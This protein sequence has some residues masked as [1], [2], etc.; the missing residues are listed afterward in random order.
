MEYKT[1]IVFSLSMAICASCN[2]AIKES[3]STEVDYDQ[4]C[5]DYCAIKVHKEVVE[6]DIYDGMYTESQVLEMCR[7]SRSCDDSFSSM[8]LPRCYESLPERCPPDSYWEPF[9]SVGEAGACLEALQNVP[10]E[11]LGDIPRECDSDA[12]CDPE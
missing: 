5:E 4:Y 10:C 8:C 12:L 6:C 3:D 1:S 7:I 11:R 9:I 2:G